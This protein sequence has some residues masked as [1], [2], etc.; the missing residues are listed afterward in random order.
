M[1]YIGKQPAVAALTAS[2]ITDGIV[3]TAK[4][5]DT[6]ITNAKLNADIISGDTAL[7]ATPADTDELLVS[8][9]GVLKRMDYS[10]IKGNPSLLYSAASTTDVGSLD[11]SSTYI[12]STHRWYKIYLSGKMAN[13]G[14]SLI[15]RYMIDGS[16]VTDNYAM[17][18]SGFGIYDHEDNSTGQNTIDLTNQVTI[19]NA[20]NE[21]FSAVLDFFNPTSTTLT[22]ILHWSVA[23]AST[24]D[25]FYGDFGVAR[26]NDGTQ[27]HNGITFYPSGGDFNEYAI[28]VYGFKV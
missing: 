3:S 9:A 10:Y 13:D 15:A 22:S 21:P 28:A 1:A 6:A 11:V 17:K 5:A 16:A 4:I 18:T 27:A 12:T 14:V 26:R 2:D 24:G 8:D 19:G 20:A 7:G 23:Y 25:V